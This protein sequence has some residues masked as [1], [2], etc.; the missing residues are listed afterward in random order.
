MPLCKN[1]YYWDPRT[2]PECLTIGYSVIGDSKDIND[3]RY[4]RYHD[5]I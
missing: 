5:L 1:G 4:Q 3:P 2:Q